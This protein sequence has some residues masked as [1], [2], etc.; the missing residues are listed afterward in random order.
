[1]PKNP[2]TYEL[3]ILDIDYTVDEDGPVI[4]I[5]GR[6]DN[7]KSYIILDK[8]FMP[9]LYLIPKKDTSIDK[10]K[11][12]LEKSRLLDENNNKINLRSIKI[13]EKNIG[14]DK[15]SVLKIYTMIPSDVPKL[16]DILKT[17]PETEGLREF[18]IPFYKRYLFSKTFAPM[19]Y[20]NVTGTQI[21]DN[22]Y[23]SNFLITAQKITPIPNKRKKFN[24][25]ALDI[26]TS[27]KS[28]TDQSIISISFYSTAGFR[29]VFSYKR[30]DYKYQTTVKDEKDLI[31]NIVHTLNTEKYDFI[32]TYNG[33]R[34]DFA[35]IKQVADKYKIPL[36]ITLTGSPL[37]FKRSGISDMAVI[38]GRPHLDIFK[39]VTGLLR[40]SLKSN[41]YSLDIISQEVLGEKK[42]GLTYEDIASFWE[43]GSKDNLEKI[44][45]YNLRDS[46]LTERLASY[47]IPNL[48]AFCNLTH[49]PPSDTCRA[50]Y[51]NIVESFLIKRAGELGHILPNRPS[52][53]EIS[54]RKELGGVKGAFVVEPITGLHKNLAVFDFKSLYPTIIIAHNISSSTLIL[55]IIIINIWNRM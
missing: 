52:S 36:D 11:E 45:R 51:G 9:Y 2:E 22:P 8:S 40:T 30:S 27:Y 20:I 43:S 10:L 29:K 12:K 28:P 31:N 35:I 55:W 16:K 14:I 54:A 6:D 17:L 26:E 41:R 44:F 21:S 53:S 4:R 34:F 24:I 19:E 46:E 15:R 1:M 13:I 32:A 23:S 5:F 38:R 18:D 49:L 47:F 50:T 48:T 37:I 42:H 39:L 33:D 7:D 3:C 25:L